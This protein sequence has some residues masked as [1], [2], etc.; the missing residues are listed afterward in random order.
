MRVAVLVMLLLAVGCK[1]TS[2]P[3]PT[4]KTPAN[5]AAV[6]EDIGRATAKL[7]QALPLIKDSEPLTLVKGAVV[8][9]TEATQ[10][11]G[12][13]GK[14][15]EREAR[16]MATQAERIR[17]LESN[18]PAKKFLYWGAGVLVAA[19]VVCGLV[20]YFFA[21]PRLYEVAAALGL[22]ACLFVGAARFI[23]AIQITGIV[24]VAGVVA[25]GG[26]FVV[27]WFMAQ[28]VATNIVQ[29]IEKAKDEGVLFINTATKKILDAVQTPGTKAVVAKIKAAEAAKATLGVKP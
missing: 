25:T 11:G 3:A 13:A 23:M 21:R 9:L 27:R 12:A 1:S 6:V 2:A 29:S 10:D 7:T 5:I 16:T 17:Q 24:I 22:L 4:S 14:Q 19:A 8:D 18:D 20:A 26:Y 15:A 28:H